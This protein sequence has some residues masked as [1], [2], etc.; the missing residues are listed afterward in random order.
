MPPCTREFTAGGKQPPEALFLPEGTVV[1]DVTVTGPLTNVQGY[2]P[3]TPVQT[4]FAYSEVEQYSLIQGEDEVR[5][6]ELLVVDGT[7]RIF[8]KAQAICDRG[9]IFVAVVAPEEAAGQVPTPAGTTPPPTD[10]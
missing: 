1:T 6:A 2:I 3:L 5:E 9:S 10:S 8:V 7:S 4:L